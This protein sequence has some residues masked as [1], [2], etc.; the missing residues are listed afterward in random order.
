[1]AKKINIV[2][3]LVTILVTAGALNWGI[4]GVSNLL[5]K[6]FNLVELITVLPWIANIVYILVGLAGLALIPTV[7]A[8]I[9]KK[10]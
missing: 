6:P 3:W 7:L 2:A 10:R 1:M 9:F 5:D 8:M 4:V